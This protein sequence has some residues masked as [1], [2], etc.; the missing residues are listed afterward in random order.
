MKIR[1]KVSVKVRGGQVFIPGVYDSENPGHSVLFGVLQGNEGSDILEFLDVPVPI[2]VQ[3]EDTEDLES[4]SE[5]ET[6]DETEAEQEEVEETEEKPKKK[7][8]KKK[9]S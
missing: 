3:E 1:L 5:D 2:A 4:E 8:K 7:K 6:E 9:V